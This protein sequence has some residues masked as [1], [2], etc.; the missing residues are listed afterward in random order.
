MLKDVRQGVRALLHAKGW[1]AVVVI[2][3]ALGIGANT[4]LFSAAN[5]LFLRKLPVRDPDALVRFGHATRTGRNDMATSTSDYGFSRMD[6]TGLTVRSTFSYP[7]YQ[8][9][10]ADNR[11]ME[12]LFACAPYGRANVVIDGQADIASAFITTGN[13]YRVLGLTA[14][15]G[16]TILPDDDRPGAAPVAVISPRYWRARFAGAPNVVG[17]TIL[18][19][20]VPVT[21][22]GVISPEFTDVQQAVREGPDIGVPLALDSQFNSRRPPP[23]EPDTPRLSQPTYWWL[24]VMGRVKP[25]VTPAQVHASLA[26]VF[27]HT[28]RA[29]MD[30][31][32]ASLAPAD[33]ASSN[34]RNRTEVSDLRVDAGNRGIYEVNPSDSRA[35]TMLAIVAVL[36]LLIVCANVAN[37]LLSRATT[38]QKE[39]SVRLSLGA[40]R[41][42][43]VR[44]LLTESVLL[45]AMGGGLGILVAHWGKQLLPGGAGRA[46]TFDWRV[47]S[48]VTAVTLATGVVFG[49]APA[50]RAT[51]MN[52]GA[53]L[54]ETSR[55]VA[56]SR[57]ILSKTLLVLQVAISIV[58]LVAAGLFMRTLHNLRNVDVGFNT[59]NL[60][61]FRVN[62]GLNRYDEPRTMA[63]YQQMM[64]R[65]HAVAGVRSVAVS[66]MPLLSGGVNS[67]AIFVAG[68]TYPSG[69]IDNDINRLVISPNFFAT[70][71]MPMRAGRGFT[72][73]DNQKAPKVVVINEAA[74]RKYFPD[75]D[76]IGQHIGSSIETAGQ[77]EI[78]GVLRDAKYDSVREPAPPTEY[79]PLLQSRMPSAV[80]QV[81]TA[82]D[83]VAVTGAI[84]D[85]VRQ[86]DPNLP[87]MDLFTQ[88]EQAEKRL[89]QEKAFAQAYTLFGGLAM[90]LASI[91]LFGL[92][93]YSVARRTNEIGIRM[94]LGAQRYD[95]VRLVMGESM[96]LVLVGVGIGLA[97]AV[98]A[99]RVVKSLLFGLAATDGLTMFVA[100]AVMVIVSGV[101]GYL[102][103]RHAARVDPLVALHYE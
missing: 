15:P 18:F 62:P 72:E 20:N 13:Y 60:V 95:V 6:P 80:F 36:V 94:A 42:R 44:Q 29:G 61:T 14:N 22:V 38:R 46:A 92:M 76:A 34:N 78:V 86:I 58:L 17:K 30:A 41:W 55:S 99:S 64:D 68:R 9:F 93:S 97:A 81:R 40:T 66:N 48:F 71:Q 91:G 67:T 101:A 74:V 77:L 69:R 7:M 43:L 52:V 45:A 88:V 70:M 50:L 3:L 1:T 8:Q 102:P 51:G 39:I 12:D 21:I 84:R 28:A 11:T 87:L 83:P 49:I 35:M 31:Y 90:L 63:L 23:G 98:A 65:L 56:G 26:T 25:G 54:K 73:R 16:R 82:S 10:V 53:M 19:N 2:S 33:R 103:A 37:L 100:T 89:V 4:A 32:L 79:V 59:Q 27:Q 5:G 57:S 85:A 47:L 75:G 24:Q 96:G